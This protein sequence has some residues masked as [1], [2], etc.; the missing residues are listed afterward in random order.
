MIEFDEKKYKMKRGI[1]TAAL[2]LGTGLTIFGYKKYENAKEASLKKPEIEVSREYKEEEEKIVTEAPIEKEEVKEITEVVENKTVYNPEYTITKDENDIYD[3]TVT[4]YVDATVSVDDQGNKVY[5]VPEG[6]FLEGNK[7]FKVNNYK[8]FY[9][10]N[11]RLVLYYEYQETITY[12]ATKQTASFYN[13]DTGKMETH[14]WYTAPNGGEVIGE[15]AVIKNVNRHYVGSDD[16]LMEEI[17]GAI[18]NQFGRV[19]E[20]SN[21]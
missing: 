14:T 8:A 7:G 6:Y 1:F 9:Q 20:N 19:R 17:D 10:P 18:S 3:V 5:S 2:A 16:E 13:S 11:G 15:Y 4:N 21:K 12:P